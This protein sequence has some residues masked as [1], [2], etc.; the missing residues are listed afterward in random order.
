MR[1]EISLVTF[2]PE[3]GV[4]NIVT[5]K[6]G[7]IGE[8][9]GVTFF[10]KEQVFYSFEDLPEEIQEKLIEEE[11]KN[12][13]EGLDYRW[14]DDVYEMWTEK[15]ECM[16]FKDIK[17]QF[18]GFWSQGDGASFTAKYCDSEK[19]INSLFLDDE[20][21]IPWLNKKGLGDKAQQA[22]K[23]WRLWFELAERGMLDFKVIRQS[24]NYVH[25]NSVTGN[26]DVD[27]G[28]LNESTNFDAKCDFITLESSFEE[29]VRGLCQEIYSD[30]EKEYEWLTSY[31]V[32]KENL[33]SRELEYNINGKEI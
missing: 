1:K 32:A 16:G 29:W 17:I 20:G 33:I 27:I 14:W 22:I 18:T 7:E 19:I 31:E 23:R 25:E 15:L 13:E 11:I 21:S 10:K 2:L 9:Y 30:L 28:G 8:K 12:A 24:H 5:K 4:E 26:M 3:G 6:V